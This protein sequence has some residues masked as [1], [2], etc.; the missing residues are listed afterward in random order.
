MEC[1]SFVRHFFFGIFLATF[2]LLSSMVN[3]YFLFDETH[4][5]YAG[6]SV[7]LLW[8][9]GLVTSVA[10][11]VLYAKGNKTILR[12]VW[13]KLVVYPLALLLFYPIIPIILT[14]AFLIT[15]NQ[16]NYEKAVISKY[17]TAFLDH[18]PHFVLRLVVVVLLGISQ[19]GVNSRYE[20][21]DFLFIL[22]M[23]TSFCSLIYTVLWFNERTSTWLRWLFLAG[24][25]YSAI[26]ACR[27]FTWAV[28][29]KATLHDNKLQ[30][31][32][33][34]LLLIIMYCINLGLFRWCG[35]DWTRSAAFA[36]AS[37]LLPTGYN[38]DLQYYQVPKQDILLPIQNYEADLVV[39]ADVQDELVNNSIE[40]S[41]KNEIE[42]EIEE[43]RKKKL[44]PM[45]SAKFL[46]LHVVF[47]TIIMLAVAVYV[48]FS[49]KLDSGSDDA[50]VI[51]HFLGVIPGLFFA[52]GKSFLMPDMCPGGDEEI[53][54]CQK[55]C[56][57]LKAGGKVCLSILFS[58]LGFLSL[59]PA[60]FWTFMYKWFTTMGA[61]ISS[62]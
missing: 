58:I 11:L 15:Q 36:V 38:N 41:E 49:Q 7:F 37:I 34:L 32:F 13:W 56:G 47:N 44:V 35:Q 14:V 62:L 60:L 52:V 51:P 29:I 48:F 53:T 10:F 50:L 1:L 22:S 24:P 21:H 4:I 61:P 45:K 46:L 26:F 2:N 43:V 57:S 17:F 28:L 59:M 6:I 30:V 27:A 3:I 5:N 40:Q 33:F 25:M 39:M 16:S 18:G 31:G 42:E 55:V 12:L 23:V 9:P 8:F 19:A 20:A 54:T